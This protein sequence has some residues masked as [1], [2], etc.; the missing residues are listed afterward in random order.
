MGQQGGPYLTSLFW[1]LLHR[2]QGWCKAQGP[3]HTF[4]VQVVRRAWPADRVS[5]HKVPGTPQVGVAVWGPTGPGESNHLGIVRARAGL[6]GGKH[7]LLV[8]RA[9]TPLP[10]AMGQKGGPDFYH[11]I[12]WPYLPGSGLVLCP[13]PPS[14][15]SPA[16]LLSSPALACELGR[17]KNA[18]VHHK[19]KKVCLSVCVCSNTP[20][21]PP[22]PTPLPPLQPSPPTLHPRFRALAQNG[23]EWS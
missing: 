15:T 16:P 17:K 7:P 23:L 1:P 5:G 3:L 22:T 18:A 20:P 11:P 19:M 21:S 12:L 2:V 13:G 8:L 4:L 9:E 14:H 6:K 10:R